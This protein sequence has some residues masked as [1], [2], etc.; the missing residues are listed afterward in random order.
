LPPQAAARRRASGLRP[1]TSARSA[2]RQDPL[3]DHSKT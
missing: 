3:P 2:F 1:P